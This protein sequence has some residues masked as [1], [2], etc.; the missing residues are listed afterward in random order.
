MF[1][2]RLNS[3]SQRVSCIQSAAKQLRYPFLTWWAHQCPIFLI[4]NR[5]HKTSYFYSQNAHCPICPI[6]LV[7]LKIINDQ[8]LSTSPGPITKF[9]KTWGK[10]DR[11]LKPFI[12]MKNCAPFRIFEL[13]HTNPMHKEKY[14][15]LKWK[16]TYTAIWLR[17]QDQ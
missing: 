16:S 10:W 13:G 5:A 15:W 12:Y 14:L 6:L 4:G 7:R 17:K 2:I 8:G 1:R 11:P 3:F 9:T